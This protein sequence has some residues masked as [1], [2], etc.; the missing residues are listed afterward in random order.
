MLCNLFDSNFEHQSCSVNFQ[1]STY[2]EYVKRQMDFDGV[3][4]FTDE[5]IN[6]PVVDEVKS[7]CKIGWLHEPQCL[8]PETYENA[9][10]NAHKFNLILTY[11]QPY[12]DPDVF[13]P[14][15]LGVWKKYI[16]KFR[17]APYAGTWLDPL[18]WGIKP[19]T[20][21]C[22][23]LIG[24]KM[25]TEGHRIRHD[26][27]DMVQKQGYQVDFYGSRGTPV[28]YSQE[29]KLQVLEDYCYS[30]VTETC[31]EDNLFTEWLLDCFAVGTIPIYWGCPNVHQFF[32]A[33]GVLQFDTLD[34]LQKILSGL[35][36][37][38]WVEKLSSVYVNLLKMREYAVTEDWLYLN[39]LREL[40]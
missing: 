11:Y 31:R 40:E 30:I 10:N 32:D 26:I 27:A 39:V 12:L 36:F 17:F 16:N 7:K 20:K 29:T 14:G 18:D 6:N 1:Q 35:S 19:K 22:S 23:M 2:I 13:D 28:N 8:H 21:L 38:K 25:S 4:L 37:E 34:R 24:S 9:L 33:K 5:W 15:R 3:T